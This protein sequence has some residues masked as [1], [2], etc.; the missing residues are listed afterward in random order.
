MSL[1]QL[2]AA[3]ETT[4]GGEVAEQLVELVGEVYDPTEEFR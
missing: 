2:L 4:E 1:A 3:D